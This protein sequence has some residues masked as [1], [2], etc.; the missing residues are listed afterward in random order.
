MANRSR[1]A[2]MYNAGDYAYGISSKG[3]GTTGPALVVDTAPSATGAGTITLVTGQTA[4]T[5]GT[6]LF[7]LNINA[8]ITIGSGTNAETV[9]PTAVSNATSP[10]YQNN[11]ASVTATFSNLH[12]IGDQV[13]SGTIGLQEAINA[14][15][16]AGGGVVLITSAW[17]QMGGTN[18]M[19]AA[20]TWTAGV[21]LLDNRAS[22]WGV[23][24]SLKVVL[25]NAQTKALF[26][27]PL[28]LIPAPGAGRMID[29]ID[30]VWENVFLTAAF[31]NG[32]V[33]QLSYDTGVTTPA[34]ATIA[35]TF[36]TSPTANQVVKVA[37]ALASSLAS[38]VVNKAIFAAAAT[39]DFITGAGHVEITIN[40]RILP[41]V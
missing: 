36:L 30:A 33:M 41:V 17:T 38:V 6:L 5:D 7:P 9:T 4:L 1:F 15:A 26:S 27:A 21:Q 13:S 22:A 18:A 12:G 25:T 39:A 40:Y 28:S 23:V 11:P 19:I 10:N 2:G 35:A 8:P 29:V 16:A 20:A 37:G 14:A 3:P 32:G 24:Q 34:S 31:A